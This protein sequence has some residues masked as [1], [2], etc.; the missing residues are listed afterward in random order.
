MYPYSDST[1]SFK[2]ISMNRIGKIHYLP[3]LINWFYAILCAFRS[4]FVLL[5]LQENIF[6]GLSREEREKSG[7]IPF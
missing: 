5:D 3:S 1:Q 2:H 4:I 7:P 6:P